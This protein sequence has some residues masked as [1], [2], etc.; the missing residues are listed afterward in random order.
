MILKMQTN[1]KQTMNKQK[2]FNTMDLITVRLWFE[3]DIN[4]NERNDKI[5]D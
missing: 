5:N 1:L 4:H 2:K 3:T